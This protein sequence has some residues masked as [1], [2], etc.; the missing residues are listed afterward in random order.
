MQ[1]ENNILFLEENNLVS[2]YKVLIVFIVTA[3]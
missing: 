1:E 3:S 2:F